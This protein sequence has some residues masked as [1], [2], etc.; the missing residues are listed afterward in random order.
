MSCSQTQTV[1]NISDP[2]APFTVSI[3]LYAHW[4]LTRESCKPSYRRRTPSV[5]TVLRI[6]E[7]HQKDGLSVQL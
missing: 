4:V 6:Y 1:E 2:E 7:K 3:P 5:N